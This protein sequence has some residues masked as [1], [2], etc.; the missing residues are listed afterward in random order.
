MIPKAEL[1]L[2]LEGAILP[3]LVRKLGKRNNI[4]IPEQIFGPNNNFKWSNFNEFLTVFD[5]SASVIR[6]PEDY[7]DVTFEYLKSM[8]EEGVIYSEIMPSPDHAANAGLSYLDHLQ[9]ITE[10]IN[11]AKQKF[12]IEC[13]II[14]TCVRHFGVERCE[15]VAKLVCQHLHPL[16]VGFGMGGNEI[17]FPPAQFAKAYQI[18]HEAGLKSNVHAGEWSG[19]E[20]IWEALHHLPVSRLSHGVRA[21]EDP[22]LVNE[23][24]ARDITLEVCPT[25]NIALGVYPSYQHHPFL[26]LKKAGVKVT[27]N[28]D[29][30]PH[31]STTVG[32][33][34]DVAKKHFGLTDDELKHIT[35]TAIHAGFA[36][37]LTKQQLL[38][39]IL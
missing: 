27:L 38:A 5:I 9:P 31:F 39:R 23:I 1:H 26:A 11:N 6:K 34:Y 4:D 32:N 16:V 13:R 19:P 25:S 21:I 3:S 14:V 8:A 22:H 15:K 28:S 12:N 24:I 36:D 2:H 20:G 7:Y 29:D 17:A 30:P 18:T 35:R 10:A 37:D 33:E